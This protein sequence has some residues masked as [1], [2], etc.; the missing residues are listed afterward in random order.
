MW[1][2]RLVALQIFFAG[3]LSATDPFNVSLVK[4]IMTKNAKDSWEFGTA[5]EALLEL[6]NVAASVF[7][8][9]PFATVSSSIEGL[10]YAKSHIT[11]G[12]KNLIPSSNTNSDPASLGVSA[13][14]IGKSN[15]SYATAA[16]TQLNTLLYNTPRA[17]NGAISHRS[18]S[19]TVW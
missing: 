7:G 19:V 4:N 8:A 6:D 18:T 5:A 2:K 13:I 17:S 15:S 1:T 14:M 9:S 11:L 10:A 12:N 3:V 16:Q